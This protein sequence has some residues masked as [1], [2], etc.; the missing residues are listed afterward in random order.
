MAI[1]DKKINTNEV[2][3]QSGA[4]NVSGGSTVETSQQNRKP[5]DMTSSSA[6]LQ[7][8]NSEI[9]QYLNSTE[10]KNLSPEDQLK[11]FK[12]R[13]GMGL[14][15]SEVVNLF[16]S[17]KKISAE[18]SQR[19]NLETNSETKTDSNT[20][21]TSANSEIS[22]KKD[23][24][25]TLKSNGV[26]NPTE[27]DLYN[28][29]LTQQK[30][31]KELT[32]EQSKLLK[33]YNQLVDAGF[34]KLTQ[35]EKDAN[36][37]VT[38]LTDRAENKAQSDEASL[39]PLE[40]IMSKSFQTK[41]AKDKLNLYMDAYLTKN[42]AEYAK[43]SDEE[44]IAYCDKKS[45]EYAKN[46]GIQLDDK[47]LKNPELKKQNVMA[48]FSALAVLE[49]AN[50]NGEK[51]ENFAEK[52]LAQRGEVA[53]S[54]QIKKGIKTIL[55]RD[56]F[57]NK[58]PEEQMI[59]LGKLVN[60]GDEKFTQMTEKEQLEFVQNSLLKQVGGVNKTLA[61]MLKNAVKTEQGRKDVYNLV[62][63]FVQDF[64][65]SPS[66]VTL[67]EYQKMLL[68]D[69]IQTT[70]I[71][72][73]N[74]KDS[75]YLETTKV[76]N[77]T[78]MALKTAGKDYSYESV[79]KELE[80]KKKSGGLSQTE[81]KAYREL[82]ATYSGII[83][84]KHRNEIQALTEQKAQALSMG[85]KPNDLVKDDIQTYKDDIHELDLHLAA[86]IRAIS[87]NKN[88]DTKEYV[89][90]TIKQ[91][92]DN[93]GWSRETVLAK[94][95]TLSSAGMTNMLAQDNGAGLVEM[96]KIDPT[97]P[98]VKKSTNIAINGD[99][100]SNEERTNFGINTINSGNKILSNTMNEVLTDRKLTT[101]NSASSF[102]TDVINSGQVEYQ[103]QATFV[104]DYMTKTSAKNGAEDTMYFAKMLTQL[105]NPSVTEGV[106]AAYN[107]VD[108]SIKSQYK[109]VIENAVSSGNYTAEQKAN[110]QN[111]MTTGNVSQTSSV[112]N[113]MEKAQAV[114][115]NN[116]GA[117]STQNVET[118]K[119]V[120]SPQI[121]KIDV[122][123][124]SIKTAG[125]Q[126]VNVQRQEITSTRINTGNSFAN[127]D[128]SK[129][130]TMDNAQQTKAAIDKSIQ[131]WEDEHKT[132]L[133]DEQISELKS[134][135]STEVLG[136]L[137]SNVGSTKN[138]SELE[139]I[140]SKATSLADLYD[141]LISVYG[142]KVQDK[143]IEALAL[144]GS[145]DQISSFAQ[146]T[147][148]SD[149]IKNLYL[150]CDSAVLKSELLNMLSPTTV[151][152]MLNAGQIEDLSMIDYKI[153]VN[154]LNAHPSLTND[155]FNKYMAYLPFDERQ[156]LCQQRM[157]V[158]TLREDDN[159][160]IDNFASSAVIKAEQNVGP[161]KG[162]DEW[163]K[164]MQE[165]QSRVK[166]PPS[167]MY[168]TAMTSLDDDYWD[169]GSGGSTKV[170]FGER[171]DKL[172]QK[173]TVYWG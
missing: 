45:A 147:K 74:A 93:Y 12:S 67:G 9:I 88:I 102:L 171:Y 64:A 115:S 79:L 162:S 42:D 110:I 14:S 112:S 106:A 161:V 125:L 167:P 159:S 29:L 127:S 151:S 91:L 164:T 34:T 126:D 113:S 153:I 148:N 46:F 6:N 173:G 104:K 31:G 160:P 103:K 124:T 114:S 19:V 142:T 158:K 17:S 150:K 90:N 68:T 61:G 169:V 105:N 11:A 66:G 27:G 7:D 87:N 10:F 1:Q 39:V 118:L 78:A 107:S 100:L 56:D 52:S 95:P 98:A 111:A 63:A 135:V 3:Q 25:S 99:L 32:P 62:T 13:Y 69:P 109:A 152:E 49:E 117:N 119:G 144:K 24:I 40:T 149:V 59:A 21:K 101:K 51:I 121:A 35:T 133:S 43:M 81:E 72:L 108:N 146:S 168:D 22:A 130:Q 89:E 143:F 123:P 83:E 86:D 48:T 140:V 50:T 97:N 129:A 172:T 141:K 136:E 154:Y 157:K 15:D 20:V 94:F 44:K 92:M 65:N 138:S 80:Q 156:R 2:V 134:S 41:P 53:L 145:A 165:R 47:K 26:E 54:N 84:P 170:K 73:E 75:S 122:Q 60:V 132:K 30:E 76:I 137:I 33:T 18:F 37:N 155:E 36:A 4:I 120:Q 82:K 116:S 166:V 57:K 16:N 96:Q 58:S 55:S 163:Q 139:Q 131:K 8:N 85:Y 71:L 70:T 77:K 23:I 28:Y 128:V 38:G 5:I